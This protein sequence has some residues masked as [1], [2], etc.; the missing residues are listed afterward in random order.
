MS[1]PLPRQSPCTIRIQ[2]ST[3]ETCAVVLKKNPEITIAPRKTLL[4]ER[5]NFVT[6]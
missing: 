2:P 1:Y 6:A 3:Q 5:L 4:Q